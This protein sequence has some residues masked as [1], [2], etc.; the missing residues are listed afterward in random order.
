MQVLQS[1]LL[2]VEKIKF[3]SG[4][5]GCWAISPWFQLVVSWL[6]YVVNSSKNYGLLLIK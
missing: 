3:S 4:L 6:S 5:L 2:L 1:S